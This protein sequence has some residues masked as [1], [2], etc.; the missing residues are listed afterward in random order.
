MKVQQITV[1]YIDHMGTDLTV[2]NSARVSFNKSKDVFDEQDEKG[3]APRVSH[4]H[5]ASS[6]AC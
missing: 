3:S 4:G 1:G 5:W 2:V 6:P